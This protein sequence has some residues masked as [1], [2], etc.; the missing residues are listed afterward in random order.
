MGDENG[1]AGIDYGPIGRLLT[2]PLVTEIMVN[3]PSMIFVEREGQLLRAN[4][5]F[6]DQDQLVALLKSLA[7]QAARPLD[8]QFPMADGR[9][10]DGSRFN[11]VL[12]SIAVD[13]ASL[14]I[15]K[16]R[17]D[18]L[19]SQHLTSRGTWTPNMA[20]FLAASVRVGINVVVSGGT[21]SGKTTLL[22]IL[23]S[24]VPTDERLV[25]IEDTGELVAAVENHVRLV[26]RPPG[27]NDP[28]LPIRALV[29]NALRM[30]PDRL[31]VGE[32]RGG[33]AYDM[34]TAMNTGHD[35]SMT[36]IHANSARDALRRLEAM[37]LMAGTDMPLRTIRQH[38]SSAIQ[39]VVHMARGA[40]GA[41][42]VVEIVEVGGM[43]GEA[44]LT[45]DVWEWTPATG[46]K[47]RGLVPR[48][49]A[50][51]HER[52]IAFPVDFFR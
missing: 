30:R 18:V 25:L 37:V 36:T 43:E 32:C 24:F 52:G 12:P 20:A 22:N 14:T 49:I 50:S 39:L 27:R 16:F 13:G 9:L 29:V 15:R 17:G 40:D 48:F 6:R 35:G 19:S 47:T 4:L 41:R 5:A 46:F 51:L 44:I 31:I 8:D 23:T 28:G 7:A 1:D 33:E 34:L 10:P 21:G 2:D 3:G 38:V 26:S 45:Q 11:A 42:R